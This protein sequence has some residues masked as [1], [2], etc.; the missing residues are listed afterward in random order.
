MSLRQRQRGEPTR[1]SPNPRIRRDEPVDCAREREQPHD[2]LE[3]LQGRQVDAAAIPVVACLVALAHVRAV[4]GAEAAKPPRDA[5]RKE[6]DFRM[7]LEV[8]PELVLPLLLGCAPW[9]KRAVVAAL[10]RLRAYPIRIAN[11][12]KFDHLQRDDPR[13]AAADAADEIHVIQPDALGRFAAAWGAPRDGL[14]R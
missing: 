13:A 2:E 11:G 1:P 9:C 6:D 3:R 8:G 5:V 10:E 4:V 7:E 14:R 12:P